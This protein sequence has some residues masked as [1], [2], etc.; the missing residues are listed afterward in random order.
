VPLGTKP[1]IIA[2]FR[3]D[4]ET[5]PFLVAVSVDGK[6][7][8]VSQVSGHYGSSEVDAGSWEAADTTWHRVEVVIDPLNI[9]GESKESNNRGVV[10]VRMIAP[11]AAVDATQSG[12]VIPRDAGGNGYTRVTEVPTGTPVEALLY[13]TYGG[14]YE[15][16]I[17]SVRWLPALDAR[18]TLSVTPCPG[19]GDFN[20]T[21]FE[22]RW[23]PPGPGT[24]DVEFSVAPLGTVPDLA[25]NNVMTKRLTVTSATPAGARSVRGE[26][27]R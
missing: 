16:V 6:V 9:F 1:H 22:T 15:A 26:E 25:D 27:R 10:D 3:C 20:Y 14:P 18:D 4:G 21:R 5:S 23:T 19:Y 24:Y 12:F 7:H 2:T 8:S 13:M 17:R 11:D